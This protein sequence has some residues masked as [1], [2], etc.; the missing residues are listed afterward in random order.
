MDV[1]LNNLQ[2]RGL[3]M[4]GLGADLLRDVGRIR[5]GNEACRSAA[6]QSEGTAVERLQAAGT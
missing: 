4:A 3:S 5:P 2:S 1:G 6:A